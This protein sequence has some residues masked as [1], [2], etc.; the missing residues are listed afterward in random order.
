M[1]EI[2][3]SV[4]R[5][6]TTGSRAQMCRQDV[7]NLRMLRQ[8]LLSEDP[9]IALYHNVLSSRQT[10][11]LIDSLTVEALYQWTEEAAFAPMR[12]TNVD[13]EKTLRGVHYQLG[14]S[15]GEPS[16]WQARRHS[17]EH[18]T[19]PLVPA[20]TGEEAARAMLTVRHSNEMIS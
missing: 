10:E 9:Y 6:H 3:R 1:N 2:C 8:E 13:I 4:S 7:S 14:L 17:H 19:A 18:V 16:T 20:E 15:R 11:Q 5:E 12:F